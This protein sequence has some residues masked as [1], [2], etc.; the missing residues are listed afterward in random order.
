MEQQQ[1]TCTH[2]HQRETLWAS[3]PDAAPESIDSC[4]GTG[5][6]ERMTRAVLADVS[7]L[8]TSDGQ[9][10]VV[11]VLA[12]I[13]CDASGPWLGQH[14]R[15]QAGKTRVELLAPQPVEPARAPVDLLQQ[16]GGAEHGEVVAG[17]RF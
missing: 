8:R 11:F 5:C 14:Q 10:E 17:S 16:P 13:S 1:Q 7:F 9:R 15:E 2:R 6:P 4:Q 3:E 12:V